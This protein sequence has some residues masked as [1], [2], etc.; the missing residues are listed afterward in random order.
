MSKAVPFM[1]QPVALDGSMSGDV[2]FDPLNISGVWFNLDFLR[3][4][5]LKHGRVCMLAV[6]GWIMTEYVHFPGYAAFN[7]DALH[8]HALN[9]PFGGLMPLLVFCATLELYGGAALVEM[10][11]G[12]GRKAG[13]F[14]FDP[15]G[16]S[17]PNADPALVAKYELAELKNG[18]LA[19][20]AYSGI[21]TA[22]T[23]T[24]KTTHELL[25]DTV[26]GRFS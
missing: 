8:A 23:L 12:S 19:M 4:A 7:T 20:L 10:M 26:A 3:E 6:P 15:I 11:R 2:G 1:P 17:G 22:C 16:F 5:E 24:G 9:A 25:F 14:G 21:V 13:D 18:R